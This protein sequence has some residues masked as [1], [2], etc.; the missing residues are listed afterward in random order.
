MKRPPA[1][2]RFQAASSAESSPDA[3]GLRPAALAWAHAMAAPLLLTV[4]AGALAGVARFAW[5]EPQAMAAACDA[6]AWERGCVG[7]SLVIQSFVEQRLAWIAWVFALAATVLRA[8]WAAAMALGAGGA[9]LVLYCTEL[10]APA[11]LLA[12]LVCA[13][14]EPR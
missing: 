7:R 10:A 4:L 2:P 13:R 6:A 5:V 11:V 14:P 12:L 3:A 8:R 1:Q 9:G